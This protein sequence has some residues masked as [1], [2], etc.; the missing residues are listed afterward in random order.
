MTTATRTSLTMFGIAAAAALAAS[1]AQMPFAAKG[2]PVAAAAE[3]L[4]NP[5][6]GGL[7]IASA[8]SLSFGPQGLLL[9]AETSSASV[10]AVQTG[11]VGPVKKLKQRVE[12]VS[13]LVAG[14]LGTVPEN[15]VIA[16]MAVN[17]D[18]G[19]I[20]L[21][22]SRKPDNAVSILTIDDEG[23][24]SPLATAEMPWARVSL[25]GGSNSKVTR[26][27][28]LAHAGDRVL[29]AGS[30]NEEFASKIFTIPTPLEHGATATIHSAETYHV[31][32]RKW[33]TKA[34]IS[35]FIPYEE[36]GKSYVVGAFA[37]T[38][39]AKFPLNDLKP[40]SQV[41][42]VSVV[43]L[44]SGNRPLDLFSYQK[45]GKRWLVAH[46]QRFH[47]P[48][49]GPSNLWAARVDMAYLNRSEPAETNENATRRDV[50]QTAGPDGIDIVD[51]LFGAAQVDK[52]NDDEAVVLRDTEGKLSLEVV[53][54]P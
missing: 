36:N 27:T 46:T 1:V 15:I 8:S 6:H 17:P 41:K 39:I 29:V 22:V 54:L 31:A 35:S 16:D 24:V 52:L 12:G 21:A 48:L 4:K 30:C 26:I 51:A 42:G 49:F 47:K 25:P 28:D 14:G 13:S 2:A 18:S 19:R 3:L 53:S 20:Y 33:E 5:Q 45:N 9:I 7:K 50:K 44:G 11:D 10:V 37:C 32:H 38:P 43:E 40:G 23:K 34:P